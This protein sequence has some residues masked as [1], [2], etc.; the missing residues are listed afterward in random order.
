MSPLYPQMDILYPQERPQIVKVPV[1][2]QVKR[3]CLS[4]ARSNRVKYLETTKNKCVFDIQ[5]PHYIK[6]QEIAKK[7]KEAER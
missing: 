2:E 1:K 5:E 7:R 6:Q 4:W 3:R